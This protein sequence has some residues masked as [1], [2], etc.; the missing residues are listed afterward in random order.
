MSKKFNGHRC[1][2]RNLTDLVLGTGPEGKKRPTPKAKKR[3]KNFTTEPPVN[4]MPDGGPTGSA[5]LNRS[6]PQF[7]SWLQTTNRE[8]YPEY[9]GEA[10]KP[11]EWFKYVNPYTDAQ[12][13][14]SDVAV[15]PTLLPQD[16]SS[17][18]MS[19][20]IGRA[21]SPGAARM[22]M[23]DAYTA[24]EQRY[25]TNRETEQL[26]NDWLSRQGSAPPPPERQVTV[27]EDGMSYTASG[28]ASQMY[29]GGPVGD[30][31]TPEALPTSDAVPSYLQNDPGFIAQQNLGVAAGNLMTRFT[32][33]N[34]GGYYKEYD[35][36]ISSFIDDDLLGGR[37]AA[38]QEDYNYRYLPPGMKAKEKNYQYFEE[39]DPKMPAGAEINRLGT[40]WSA[41]TV[42]NLATAFDPTF[43]GSMRHS[44]YINRAFQGDGNYTAGRANRGADYQE[45]DILFTGR[46]TGATG[47]QGKGYRAFKKLAEDG[48]GY[49]SHSDIITSVDTDA[50][51]N[52][53]YNVMGGN[54][55]DT[56]YDRAFTAKQLASRYT[57]R[58]HNE[59]VSQQSAAYQMENNPAMPTGY[60][61][62]G[63]LALMQQRFGGQNVPQYFGGG[64]TGGSGQYYRQLDRYLRQKG[65][66]GPSLE[67]LTGPQFME[68]IKN[69]NIDAGK[70]N[71]L[72]TGLG[73]A[74]NLVTSMGE[75]EDARPDDPYKF[76]DALGGALSGA[77]QGAM[78]GLPGMLVGGAFGLGK[79]LFNHQKDKNE[80]NRMQ[81]EAKD[82]RTT[83]NV[84]NAQDFSRQVLNTYN[85]E[86]VGGSYY[87]RNGGPVDYETEKSEVILASPNDP[88]IAMG[89]GKYK[90]KSSNLY[91]GKGP[92]HEMGGIPTKGA[93]EPF[94]DSMG[95][96]QDSPYVFSD[97]KEMR[98]DP[99]SILSMIS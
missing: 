33:P 89:Q 84:G 75:G 40:P 26:Y 7:Q 53:T 29:G 30:T 58:M 60:P 49:Q 97:A 46:G 91:Q 90:Q 95:Q 62:E 28:P 18:Y 25:N 66:Q 80:F 15:N 37:F 54:M 52:K 83:M 24:N 6:D 10:L 22:T 38:K 44:D 96:E 39:G 48:A 51:G 64:G 1:E 99:S 5:P 43:Q 32:N 57:G 92:S 76:T 12:K 77:G 86:G 72:G 4:T 41:G 56:L 65:R 45:G 74:G 61:A 87:A 21:S 36:R 88:P 73:V 69:Q 27:A 35:P 71:L 34:T 78:F 17:Q 55:G 14:P 94:K 85:Q 16:A 81:E 98:F 93:T 19:Q 23:A 20:K 59:G 67:G 47:T 42:S 50:D 31:G 8:F 11:T 3:S 63:S 9:S 68:A 2:R 82:E 79:S 13:Y 70:A